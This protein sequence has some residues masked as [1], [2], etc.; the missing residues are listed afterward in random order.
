[1]KKKEEVS[2]LISGTIGKIKERF[3]YF[4]LLLSVVI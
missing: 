2:V 1:M 3:D 4:N